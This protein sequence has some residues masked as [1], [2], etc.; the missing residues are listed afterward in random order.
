MQSLSEEKDFLNE[1]DC[2]GTSKHPQYTIEEVE[3]NSSLDFIIAS[4][5][6]G[7]ELIVEKMNQLFDYFI[8]KYSRTKTDKRNKA[9]KQELTSTM[10][11]KNNDDK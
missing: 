5:G 10:Q 8:V 3:I 11:D 4:D 7:D 1:T 9:L 6:F 2:I